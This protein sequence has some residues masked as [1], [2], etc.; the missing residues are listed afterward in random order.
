MVIIHAQYTIPAAIV[1]KNSE[2]GYLSLKPG[3]YLRVYRIDESGNG[4]YGADLMYYRFRFYLQDETVEKPILDALK[5]LGAKFDI[6]ESFD[7]GHHRVC[8]V[9]CINDIEWK[10]E[11]VRYPW[12]DDDDEDR[13]DED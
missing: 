9:A 11:A 8:Y 1:F 4:K 13:F 12:D 5:E 7:Y 6:Y 3:E 2:G 10:Y